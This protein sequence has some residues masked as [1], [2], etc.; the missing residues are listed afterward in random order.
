MVNHQKKSE[1]LQETPVLLPAVVSRLQAWDFK[2]PCI[3]YLVFF[4]A[5]ILLGIVAFPED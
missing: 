2:L 1:F 5:I 4:I 3:N